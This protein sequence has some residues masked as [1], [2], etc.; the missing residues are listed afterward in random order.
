MSDPADRRIAIE[1][2]LLYLL[3]LLLLPGFAFVMLLWLAHQHRDRISTLARCHLRQ[4][5]F[6]SLWAGTLLLLV[7]VIIIALGGFQSP[8][9]WVVLI[10]YFICCHSLFIL[11][12][13]F[14]LS[15][16]MAGQPYIY[17]LPGSQRWK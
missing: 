16:A 12:G 8:M 4:T 15:R 9:T 7:T 10:L 13:V 5:I 3:N 2:E 14:G 17:F 1:A 6:A 11:L